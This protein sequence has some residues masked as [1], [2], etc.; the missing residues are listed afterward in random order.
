MRRAQK[1]R[2]DRAAKAGLAKRV[3][4][5]DE[6][7]RQ[8]SAERFS[9]PGSDQLWAAMIGWDAPR[10]SRIRLA[11]AVHDG[12]LWKAAA[13]QAG[14]PPYAAD[15]VIAPFAQHS[16]EEA[17]R[18]EP[19]DVDAAIDAWIESGDDYSPSDPAPKWQVLCNLAESIGLEGATPEGYQEDWEVWTGMSLAAPARTVL[20]ELLAQTEQAALT[21]DEVAKSDNIRSL[22]TVIRVMWTALA[23]GDEK[24]FERMR[25]VASESLESMPGLA[26]PSGLSQK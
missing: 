7:R 6:L 3:K 25:R 8:P 16:P 17:S 1:A 11:D 23:Y 13:G 2:R 10:R 4:S 12:A 15:G 26:V 14:V 22:A 5:R 20:M 24:T 9:K 18:L 21:L 19:V